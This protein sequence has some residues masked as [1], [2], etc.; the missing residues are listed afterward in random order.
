MRFYNYDSSRN[1]ESPFEFFTLNSQSRLQL[2]KVEVK[3]DIFIE[4]L[5]RM[6]EKHYPKTGKGLDSHDRLRGREMFPRKSEPLSRSSEI[7]RH[8][9]GDNCGFVNTAT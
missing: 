6:M 5:L 7:G 2:G 1:Y 4:G 9:N 8:E 3:I